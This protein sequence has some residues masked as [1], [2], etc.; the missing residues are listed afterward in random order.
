MRTKVIGKDKML[1]IKEAGV[2]EKIRKNAS[3]LTRWVRGWLVRVRVKR[4]QKAA[5]FI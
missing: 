4:M 5:R 3:L 2:Q 1:Q